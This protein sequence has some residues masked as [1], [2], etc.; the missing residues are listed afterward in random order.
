[1]TIIEMEEHWTPCEYPEKPPDDWVMYC[2]TECP[3]CTVAAEVELN[4]H[5]PLT[6]W[7][8]CQWYMEILDATAP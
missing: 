7:K 2:G 5:D 3:A 8:A 6:E 1:M 4:K